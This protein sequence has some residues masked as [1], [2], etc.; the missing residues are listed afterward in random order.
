MTYQ[1]HLHLLNAKKNG[2]LR[3]RYRNEWLLPTKGRKCLFCYLCLV[4]YKDLI[5]VSSIRAAY[6]DYNMI[7]HLTWYIK[8]EKMRMLQSRSLEVPVGTYWQSCQNQTFPTRCQWLMMELKGI[9]NYVICELIY[10]YCMIL[11]L[12]SQAKR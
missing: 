12:L 5:L 4:Q 10:K 1:V 8:V 7:I 3:N 2:I 6:I 11:E 9:I